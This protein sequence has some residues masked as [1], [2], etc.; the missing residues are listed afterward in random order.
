MVKIVDDVPKSKQIV[1]MIG[2]VHFEEKNLNN[3]A[4]VKEGPCQ[5]T[6]CQLSMTRL[7]WIKYNCLLIMRHYVCIIH[8]KVFSTMILRY[9]SI[10]PANFQRYC[11]LGLL[12]LIHHTCIPTA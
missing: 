12:F 7:N 1:S 2:I 8:V 6:V 3:A 5:K 11:T 4:R 9:M 10:A